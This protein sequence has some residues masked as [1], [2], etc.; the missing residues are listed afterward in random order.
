MGKKDFVFVMPTRSV[1]CIFCERTFETRF[2]NQKCCGDEACKKAQA[3]EAY[4]CAKRRKELYRK[5]KE[6]RERHDEGTV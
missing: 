1:V 5:A 2:P 4:A 3:A 6:R